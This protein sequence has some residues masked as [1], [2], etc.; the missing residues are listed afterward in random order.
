MSSLATAVTPTL[1]S[2]TA[3]DAADDDDDDDNDDI[4]DDGGVDVD[5]GVEE[6]FTN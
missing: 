1:H 4:C 6:F 3:E 2:R 5:V